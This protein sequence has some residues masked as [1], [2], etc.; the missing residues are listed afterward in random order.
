MRLYFIIFI[1][2]ISLLIYFFKQTLFEDYQIRTSRHTLQD[3][4]H[5]YNKTLQPTD[6]NTFIKHHTFGIGS[7]TPNIKNTVMPVI[8]NTLH[9]IN[10]M[11][12]LQVQFINL[13][14]IEK[15]TDSQKNNLYMVH[16]SV[17]ERLSITSS[18]LILLFTITE[19]NK[20]VIHSFKRESVF[21]GN[22]NNPT[23]YNSNHIPFQP[24]DTLLK[25]YLAV[26]HYD[27]THNSNNTY[28]S[29]FDTIQKPDYI[30][31][32]INT[33]EVSTTVGKDTTVQLLDRRISKQCSPQIT[34]PHL[35]I[36]PTQFTTS[37]TEP[38]MPY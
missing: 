31:E 26:G 2:I 35:Y 17:H 20:V 37:F 27:D 13:D 6:T 32:D 19:N 9:I 15:Y 11:G 5:I 33:L 14:R 34:P 4:L 7:F 28:H 12:S 38:D 23:L 21:I 10:Q 16:I 25:K 3:V 18:R 29:H 22:H 24:K 8:N 30:D 36:N 1:I